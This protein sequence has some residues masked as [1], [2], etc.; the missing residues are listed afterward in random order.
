MDQLRQLSDECMPYQAL[1]QILRPDDL[2]IPK[3]WGSQVQADTA[4]D[5]SDNADTRQP[6]A[7]TMETD[8]ALQMLL[9]VA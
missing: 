3:M 1:P 8:A 9:M 6:Y 2:P 4:E 5:P 7:S